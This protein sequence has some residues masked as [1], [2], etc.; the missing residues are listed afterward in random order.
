MPDHSPPPHALT[1]VIL[2]MLASVTVLQSAPRFMEASGVDFYHFW[3]V[4]VARRLTLGLGAPY[5]EGARYAA[6]LKDY[7]ATVNQPKLAFAVR[8]WSSPDFTATPL[9]YTV[10]AAVSNDYTFSLRVFQVLQLASLLGGFLLLGRLFRLDRFRV[11]CLALLCVLFYQPVMSDL[12]VVNLGSLQFV[13]LAAVVG[14][15]SALS[16][17]SS[18]GPRA[19]LGAVVLAA[20]AVL[21]L[22]KPNV[23]L[24]GVLLAAHV[25]VRQ[26]RRVFVAAAVPAAAVTLLALIVPCLYFQ[27]WTVWRQWYEHVY[28]SNP[29]ALVR[30]VAHG[31]YSTPVLLGSWIGANVYAVAIGLSAVL[32]A[33]L[34]IAVGWRGRT[35][36]AAVLREPHVPLAVALLVTMATSPIYWLHYYVLS[37]IPSLWLLGAG[38]SSRYLPALGAAAVLMSSGGLGLLLW[39]FGW[40]D[41]SPPTIALSWLP[42]WSAVLMTI[43]IVATVAR[44]QPTPDPVPRRPERRKRR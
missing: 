1:V 9:L 37:L 41:A 29:Y 38:A 39:W 40:R 42:L 21:T 27:S 14:L 20:L 8:F 31:N 3:G 10:F 19:A 43:P 36:I 18:F 6:V 15:A 13:Y 26:G 23:A 2:V 24:V 30:Q 17:V 12:R 7:A 44:A 33:S 25:L 35:A 32:V 11:L 22:C 28:G 5:R 4:P 16:R 34:M